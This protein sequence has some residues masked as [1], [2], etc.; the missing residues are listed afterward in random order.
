M[1]KQFFELFRKV[2]FEFL[3]G[4]DNVGHNRDFRC[5]R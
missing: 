4:V 2:S 3:V 1:F 5:I